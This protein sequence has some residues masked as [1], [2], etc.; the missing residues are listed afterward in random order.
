MECISA[1]QTILQRGNFLFFPFTHAVALACR[2]INNNKFVLDTNYCFPGNCE[3][4]R[5]KGG[6][7]LIVDALHNLTRANKH[8]AFFRFCVACRRDQVR[9][10]RICLYWR[11][12]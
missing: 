9:L 5:T 10:G 2:L 3:A 7:L 4:R 12:R 1:I 11:E 8:N 6:N